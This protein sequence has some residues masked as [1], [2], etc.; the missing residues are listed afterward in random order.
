[1][2]DID[3]FIVFVYLSVLLFIGI[4]QKSKQSGFKG[5]ARISDK[6]NKSK[7]M[8]VATIFVS[9]I[10]GGTT[11]GIAEK[12][13]VGNI[14]YSYALIL[15]IPIDILIANYLVPRLAKHYGAESI[16][17]IISVHYGNVGRFI[18]GISAM[19][20]SI[21][22]LAAQISVSGRIFEY[23]LQM[24]YIKGVV[25]SY[26]IVVIYT[27]IGGLRSVFFTNQLQFFAILIAIPIIS[28][29]GIYGLGVANFFEQIPHEKVAIIDNPDLI[30][31]T[32][33]AALGFAV[34]NLFP[35][36][37]QRVLI[38]KDPS[39]TTKAIY[40]KS[41][42]YFVFL[43]FITLNG[44]IAYITYPEIAPRLAL[45]HLIDQIIPIGLQG[46]VVVGLL[47]AV[48]STADS[49]LNISAITLVKDIINPLLKIKNPERM[50]KIARFTNIIIG[51]LA[52]LLALCFETV[53]DLVIFVA[54]FWG[55]II[56][57]PL[58]FA[59]YDIT[60]KTKFMVLSSICGAAAFIIWEL[61][62]AN[63]ISLKGVFVGTVVNIILFLLSSPKKR[64][65]K[66]V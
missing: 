21:G 27:T 49:D 2:I 16:G 38:N 62:F 3:I 52:I 40:I 53:V 8:L 12:A 63:E 6:V 46:V 18:A 47:A 17:D 58:V 9:S 31:T 15:V 59:L 61:A 37:I 11:F 20:V 43:I 33:Y 5:F 48:M 34:M 26:T 14:A 51:S 4:Y 32:I 39:Q 66:I 1:V 44:I 41:A 42:I 45:P 56:L 23:I 7:L 10:G 64:L 28:I 55:P 50:L 29:F 65:A 30:Q 13:F 19:C 60:I 57:V 36:Y 24:D 22:F 54:G 35:T 25:L